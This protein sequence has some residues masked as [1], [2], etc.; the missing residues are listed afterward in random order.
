MGFTELLGW[1]V[2]TVHDTVCGENKHYHHTRDTSYRD[3]KTE[4]YVLDYEYCDRWG[5]VLSKED[6]EDAMEIDQEEFEAQIDQEME[7]HLAE[8]K[9][10]EEE[11]EEELGPPQFD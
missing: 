4:E 11:L 5:R 6:V 9:K 3:P 2:D 7:E 10:I 1:V 8:L